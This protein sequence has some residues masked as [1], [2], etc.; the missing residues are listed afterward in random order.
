MQMNILTLPQLT[1]VEAFKEA[2]LAA[3]GNRALYV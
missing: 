1:V 2:T 3:T